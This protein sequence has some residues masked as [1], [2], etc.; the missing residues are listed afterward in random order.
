[1]ASAAAVSGSGSSDCIAIC[2]SINDLR[3]NADSFMECS[4]TQALRIA[5]SSVSEALF[6]MILV[7]LLVLVCF[8]AH[9]KVLNM[10]AERDLAGYVDSSEPRKVIY[11]ACRD[12]SN[13]S[14]IIYQSISDVHF[15]SFICILM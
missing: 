1:M 4:S 6:I 3:C 13:S 9:G 8:N 11:R 15:Q 5:D 10:F 7:L 12:V 2:P 14:F